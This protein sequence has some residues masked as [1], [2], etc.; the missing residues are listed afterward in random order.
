MEQTERAVDNYLAALRARHP[1]LNIEVTRVLDPQDFASSR[2]LHEG[3]L[4]G[5]APGTSPDRFFPHRTA[6]RGLY[7]AG[8]TTYPGYGVPTAILSGILAAD[9]VHHDLVQSA[10]S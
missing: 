8:Q 4:Y 9:A 2:Y 6:L 7:L 5:F 3:A 10:R 1:D